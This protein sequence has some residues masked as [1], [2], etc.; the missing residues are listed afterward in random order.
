MRSSI[1]FMLSCTLFMMLSTHT[2]AEEPRAAKQKVTGI[3][4]LFFRA[5]D[6]AKLAQWYADHLGIDPVPTTYE[7]QPWQQQAG[8]TVFAP[9]AKANTYFGDASKQWMINFRVDN[10]DAMV[11]QLRGAGI[12]VTVDPELYPNGR[13]A[14]LTDPEG[15]PIQLWEPK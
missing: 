9:F 15:N 5:D 2:M 4:G 10:L 3:G 12:E 7:T 6:P 14:R 1:H 13:F 8:G 11:Q